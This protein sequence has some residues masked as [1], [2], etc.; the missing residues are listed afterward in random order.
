MPET[1][2]VS[3]GQWNISTAPDGSRH[4]I[5]WCSMLDPRLATY[6]P[7]EEFDWVDVLKC[8]YTRPVA[9]Q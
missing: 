7:L 5:A 3:T 8:G 6:I 9:Q 4:V 2:T 1:T